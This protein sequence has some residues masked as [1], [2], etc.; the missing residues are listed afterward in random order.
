MF[1]P[2]FSRNASIE[3]FEKEG[4]VRNLPNLRPAYTSTSTVK[5][6]TQRKQT[7]ELALYGSSE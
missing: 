7:S 3:I 2:A 4:A 5:R 6:M 1:K